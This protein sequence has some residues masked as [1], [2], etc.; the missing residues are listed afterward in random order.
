MILIFWCTTFELKGSLGKALHL[1]KLFT[2]G[3]FEHL[4]DIGERVPFSRVIPSVVFYIDAFA[5]FLGFA[6]RKPGEE[7]LDFIF[8]HFKHLLS[9]SPSARRCFFQQNNQNYCGLLYLF[10]P[11]P[12][13]D[14]KGVPYLKIKFS[15]T[16]TDLSSYR[17]SSAFFIKQSQRFLNKS[18]L[19]LPSILFSPCD[20]ILSR[21]PNTH[22]NR[23]P[24]PCW[25]YPSI[26]FW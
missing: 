23:L 15:I 1:L 4:K 11:K 13:R 25:V 6:F 20:Y 21:L 12:I 9:R 14:C 19:T 18:S 22:D 10:R 24:A 26:L 7:L 3:S 5:V 16:Y 2:E 17:L 8:C